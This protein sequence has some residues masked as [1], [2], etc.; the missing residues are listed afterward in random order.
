MDRRLVA[1][2]VLILGLILVI[3]V[4][5]Y[6]NEP[7]PIQP[8]EPLPKGLLIRQIPT[9][10]DIIFTSIRS[11]LQDSDC[12]D[13]TYQLKD[14]FL[15]DADCNQKIYGIDKG[16]ASPRQL[17]LMEIDTGEVIQIT[18]MDC[19]FINGQVI[20]TTT[21]MV[22]TAC[23]DTNNNGKID[24]NDQTDLYL[25]DLTLEEMYCLTYG[26]GLNSINNPDYSH[27]TNKI[28][29]S[30]Q[31]EGVFHNYLF[32][33]DPHNN[34]IQLTNDSAYMD[35]DCS[36]SEDGTKI[37][38]SRLPQQDF[39]WTIP[40]Q[41]WMMDSD[42][43]NMEKITN[44]GLN[45]EGEENLGVYPIGIDADP[46]FSPDNTQIV[47][48]RLKTGTQN[49]PFGIFELLVIDVLTQ[50]EQILDATYANMVPEWNAEGILFVRQTGAINP[51]D[52]KQGLYVYQDDTFSE[53][54]AFPYN[55][56]PIGAFGG[57]WIQLAE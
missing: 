12:L 51:M 42:G 50:S 7:I 32:T 35:F 36:W 22:H 19:L 45:L 9:S 27:V 21:L 2:I 28:L 11:V 5:H 41:V 38:F 54:E 8:P 25:L 34:L 10:S 3:T 20:N 43:T 16:L 18:N 6:Q 33:I 56:F 13:A 30:A 31:N 24:E 1:A 47:F 44:G 23:S 37:V 29:F 46:H 39:P 14:D 4:I 57:S 53:L 17:F 55:V 49:E 52:V 40:S 48:S 15:T 26:F